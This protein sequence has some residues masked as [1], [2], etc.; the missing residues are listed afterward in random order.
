MRYFLGVHRF[1]PL[2]AIMEILDG[3]LVSSDV[4]LTWSGIGT[5]LYYSTMTG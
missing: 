4:G 5:D 1:A 3:F 2:L